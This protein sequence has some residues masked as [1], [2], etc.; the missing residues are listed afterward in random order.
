MNDIAFFGDSDDHFLMDAY[1][2][3]KTR[4]F[5][6]EFLHFAETKLPL[7]YQ[8]RVIVDRASYAD[9]FLRTMMKNESL[10]GT[11]VISNPFTESCDDK[12]T[13]YTICQKLGI[14]FPKTI[15]LPK[16][17]ADID[18]HEQVDYPN[19]DSVFSQLRF[20]IVLKPHD[21]YA[22]DYVSIVS[23]I[24]EAKRI[25]ESEKMKLVLLAQ[26]FI[27]SKSFYRVYYFTNKEPV[28]VKY[29]PSERHYMASDYSDIRSIYDKIREYTIKFNKTI[30]YDVN[31]CEWAIDNNDVPYLI[32]GFNET[33]DIS[34]DFIP[35]EYYDV[36]LERF[37]SLIAEKY[38]STELNRWPFNYSP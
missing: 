10:K 21:G 11:Y 16:F 14:P 33:P 37:V 35:Q 7:D 29:S 23:N 4:G 24:D 22:W 6:V 18:V 12:I 27:Q 25:Y 32:D 20:P 19:L 1:N 2:I 15:V 36:L 5:P 34:P 17:N 9:P 26:E 13:E 31:A 38:R 8:F 30:G 3:L 28:F